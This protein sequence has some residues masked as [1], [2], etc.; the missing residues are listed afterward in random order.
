MGRGRKKFY[1]LRTKERAN[2]WAALPHHQ[3]TLI[4]EMQMMARFD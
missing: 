4:P 2:I 1:K 3:S